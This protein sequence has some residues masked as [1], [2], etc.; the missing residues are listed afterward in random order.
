MSTETRVG[1]EA[2]SKWERKMAKR[3]AEKMVQ[4]DLSV[5]PNQRA[6]LT[7]SDIPDLE[8]ELLL[9]IYTKRGRFDSAHESTASYKNFIICAV[10]NFASDIVRARKRLKRGGGDR[11]VSLNKEI[12][13]EE[14]E[15]ITVGEMITDARLPGQPGALPDAMHVLGSPEPEP[16]L[17][18]DVD[19]LLAQ[20]NARQRE[21]GRR[22][23]DGDDVKD[24]GARIGISRAE[25]YR[26][27]ARMRRTLYAE[28]LKDYLPETL[29]ERTT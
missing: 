9:E 23:M 1:C 3:K 7:R 18:F 22:I 6:G 21:I 12:S 2:F 15:G 20:L 13:N 17:S 28:G 19:R 24:I 10:N 25:V 5:P 14:G 26:E 27:I 11:L 16:S 8:Q 4:D 29:K